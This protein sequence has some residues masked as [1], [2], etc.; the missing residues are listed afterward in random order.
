M[1]S[2]LLQIDDVSVVHHKNGHAF[3]AVDGVS[4]GVG[5]GETVGLVG[6]SGCGKS[7]LARTIMGLYPP[8][9][10]NILFD[11]EDI[12]KRKWH[13]RR[14]LSVSRRLQMIFQDP[15]Q[16]LNPRTTV[17][18]IVEEP[19]MVHGVRGREERRSR[20]RGLLE[21]VGLRADASERLPHEFS[22]GQRQRV[23]I[24][25]A[26]ALTPDLV[27]CDEPVS[28]LDLSVQAQVLNLLSDLQDELKLSY[29]F[30][31]HD[32]AV[33]RHMAS[34]VVIMYLGRIVESG[35]AALL[36]GSARHPY[37]KALI[38]AAPSGVP[39]LRGQARVALGDIPSPVDRPKGC[40]FHTRCPF[41]QAICTEIEPPLRPIS[42]GHA[43]ACHFS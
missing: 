35:P 6:E 38:A 1:N 3:K 34:R 2:D 13:R 8:A 5:R 12:T 40:A 22:G 43:A 7:T 28:A 18:R 23:G 29:L 30:I 31:S 24:A 26:L 41:K 17:G 32:L 42:D 15:Q 9:S 27:I 21:K 37:T 33:V 20:V 10:G 11:G 36:W 25:R 39:A 4:L 14:A 19:L 16:S